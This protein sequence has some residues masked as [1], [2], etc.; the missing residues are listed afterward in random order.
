MTLNEH[1]TMAADASPDWVT[2][3]SAWS[4][5]ETRDFGLIAVT[6]GS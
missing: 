3:T 2:T 1:A 6:T 4:D 5:A